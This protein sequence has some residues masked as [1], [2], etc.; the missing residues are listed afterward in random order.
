MN[1]TH[2]IYIAGHNGMVGSAIHRQLK[3]N[4]FSNIITRDRKDLDLMNQTEVFNFFQKNQPEYVFD[5]AA[6]VGGI[7]ANN[8]YPA[9]F[10]YQNLQI[11]NHIIH[12]AHLNGVK[13]LLFLGSS[14]IYPR[15]CPQPML[16]RYLLTGP[17]E[18][19][20]DAYAIAKISGIVMC[21]AY[22][23]QYGDNFLSIMPT[24]LYGPGDNFDLETSHVLPALIRKFHEAKIKKLKSV[25]LWGTGIAKREFLHVE[26]M[27]NA[28]IFIMQNIDAKTIYEQNIT[29]LNVGTGKD[30]SIG[31]LADMIREI[32]GFNGEI[33]YDTEKPDGM[34]VKRLNVER[35]NQM[36]WKH[37][38]SIQ[39]GIQ[40]TYQ[41]YLD[42]LS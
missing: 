23:R 20:N 3:K 17:L 6:K 28:S 39:D 9:E 27:A 29:H 1:K 10:I 16:E 15:E 11:Q 30:I 8:T 26:D 25:T 34:L 31:E 14:C 24:N 37:N 33:I 7:L 40:Q 32:I 13:K 2:K 21:H 18:P 4:G 35:L 12:A 19:T 5:A 38:I 41:W 22:Y 36:G 42:Y